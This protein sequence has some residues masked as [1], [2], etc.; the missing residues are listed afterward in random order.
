MKEKIRVFFTENTAMN[1]PFMYV[2]LGVMCVCFAMQYLTMINLPVFEII[3]LVLGWTWAI[4]A[5][6]AQS[7]EIDSE[8]R[9]RNREAFVNIAV[10]ITVVFM[11]SVIDAQLNRTEMRIVKVHL[12]DLPHSVRTSYSE[13]RML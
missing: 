7:D 2:I 9:E 4:C 12:Q 8:L 6:D 10:W 5:K 11:A 13:R 3:L 1:I